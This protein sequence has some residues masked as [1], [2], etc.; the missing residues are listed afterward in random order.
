MMNGS[1][2]RFVTE[3]DAY[4]PMKAGEKQTLM[5][6]MWK[7]GSGSAYIDGNELRQFV[8]FVDNTPH[9]RKRVI[10]MLRDAADLIEQGII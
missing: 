5:L 1:S 10:R 9:G 3:S 6:S 2:Q 4:D 8:E 7:D